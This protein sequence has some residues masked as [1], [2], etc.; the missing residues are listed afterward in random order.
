VQGVGAMSILRSFGLMA[1]AVVIGLLPMAARA[2]GRPGVREKL[3]GLG[4]LPAEAD[5]MQRTT[6][7]DYPMTSHHAENSRSY[8]SRGCHGTKTRHRL[9][10]L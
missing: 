8:S 1:V 3:R 2:W 9:L 7:H 10:E 5:L 4:G 6:T